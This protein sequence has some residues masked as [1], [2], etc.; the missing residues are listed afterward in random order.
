MHLQKI[1]EAFLKSYCNF[2][3]VTATSLGI[4]GLNTELADYSS[5]RIRQ[6]LDE[7]LEIQKKLQELKKGGMKNSE[8]LIDLQLLENKIQLEKLELTHFSPHRRDPSG[9][10]SEIL[11]GIWFLLVRPLPKEERLKGILARLEKTP[12]LFAQARALIENP[13]RVW[14]QIACDEVKGLLGFLES[15]QKETLKNYPR[16]RVQIQKAFELAVSETVKF[17]K[18]LSQLLKSAKGSFAISKQDFDFMLKTYHGFSEDSEEVLKIGKRIFSETEEALQEL[19]GQIQKGAKWERL[20]DEIKK[21]HPTSKTLMSTYQA[22][23][24]R[25]KKFI[26]ERELVS[27]PPREKL[28]V[29]ETPLFARSTIPYAAYIDPPLFAKDRTGHFFVTPVTGS[30]SQKMNDYLREHCYASL[31]ITALH[32]GYPGHHLQFVYQ[33]NLKRPIRKIFNCSSY[34]EGWALYCEEMMGEEGFYDPRAKLLQLKDKLWRACRVIVDVG[35]HTQG[36]TDG[37]AVN[38]LSKNARM[39]KSAAR[40]D[41]NWYTQRPTVPLSYLTGML[42]IKALREEVQKKWGKSFSLKKFHNWFLQFG[43]IPISLIR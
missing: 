15:C 30:K 13:P 27:I 8:D 11:Y 12:D 14:V 7:L 39:A 4:P 32:E 34:Y 17:Q 18:Y 3:P 26:R 19:A 2:H 33:A 36:M 22:Q 25:L 6:Y 28:K 5:T 31:V 1:E 9:Y 38:F 23:V 21:D 41:V 37:E 35:M 40:A 24:H 16:A 43:A 42:K 20:I 10:V 29:I